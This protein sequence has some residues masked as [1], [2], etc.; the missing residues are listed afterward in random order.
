MKSRILTALGGALITFGSATGIAD[1]VNPKLA[2]VLT[3]VG[4]ALTVF[5]DRLF[6]KQDA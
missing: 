3:A 1:A 5:N 6:G 4:G 2:L